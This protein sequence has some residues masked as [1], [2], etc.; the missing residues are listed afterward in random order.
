MVEKLYFCFKLQYGRSFAV[1]VFS[2]TLRQVQKFKGGGHYLTTSSFENTTLQTR[3][4]DRSR[5]N[6]HGPLLG[7]TRSIRKMLLFI[8]FLTHRFSE[9]NH[10]FS[11]QQSGY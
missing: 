1:S 5:Q 6:D 9:A 3:G 4:K 11:S 8:Y 2:G 10:G 7:K